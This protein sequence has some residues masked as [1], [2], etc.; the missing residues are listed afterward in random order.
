[1]QVWRVNIWRQ[2]LPIFGSTTS[3]NKALFF[4]CPL[5]LCRYRPSERRVHLHNLKLKTLIYHKLSE[6][7]KEPP[8]CILKNTL[9]FGE[10]WWQVSTSSAESQLQNWGQSQSSSRCVR[11]RVNWSVTLH[12]KLRQHDGHRRYQMNHGVFFNENRI[13]LTSSSKAVGERNV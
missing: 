9:Y 1:M 4:V 12:R 2:S 10:L 5:I 7:S 3:L 6:G 13:P 11:M 8:S